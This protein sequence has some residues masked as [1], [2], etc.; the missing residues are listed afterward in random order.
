MKKIQSALYLAMTSVLFLM[1][2]GISLKAAE[3]ISHQPEIEGPAHSDISPPM[4]EVH[5]P[6]SQAG[7]VQRPR[8]RI[9]QS[10]NPTSGPDGALQQAPGTEV[11]SVPA[12]SFG[13]V[14]A[15]GYAPPDTNMAVGPNYIVQWVNLS[16]SVYDK[17]GNKLLGPIG[18]NTIWTGFGAPCDSTNSSDP[19]A[20]YDAIA[21][22]WVMSELAYDNSGHYF[23][24]FAVSKGPDPTGEYFRYSYSFSTD[25]ND[26]PKVAIWPSGY[27][28][29]YNMFHPILGG[30]LGYSFKGA[31][32]CAYD[33]AGMLAGNPTAASVCFQLGSGYGGLLPSDLDGGA[34]FQPP[35]GSPGFFVNFGINSLNLWKLMPNFATPSSSTFTGPTNIPVAA[36]S[37]ACSGGGTCIPQLDTTQQ[38][39]SLADRLMYRLAYRNFG[40]HESIV[41]NHSVTAGS[42]VGVRW[43]EIRSPNGTPTVYQQGTYAPDANYRWM[44]SVAMDKAGNIGL[45]YSVSST[46]MHPSIRYTGRQVSDP[47]GTMT[48]AE[49]SIVEGTGSQQATLSRWGDY[50]A[51]RI[52]PRDDCTFWYTNEYLDADGTFNWRTQIASFSF[53]SCGG[54]PSPDFTIAVQ[55]PNS[56]TVTQGASG[57]FTVNIAPLNGFTGTVALSATVSPLNST[58]TPAFNPPSVTGAGSSTLTVSTTASTTPGPYT[59]TITGTSGSL[60]HS[61][62]VTLVVNPVNPPDFS[63]SASPASRNVT[64][65]NSTT[66]TVTV[67]RLYGFSGS[68][69]LNVSGL[70]SRSSGSSSPNPV[71]GSGNSSTLTIKTNRN[72]PTGTSPLTITGTSGSLNHSTGVSLVVQ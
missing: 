17:T 37:A 42:S 72:T 45:G 32:A 12:T 28:A 27:F 1:L 19:I 24:C 70:P 3:P 66:Y 8:P 9:P 55:P 36:F 64:R 22:R 65:G 13:G 30:L 20:Q 61:T 58:I 63:I 51:M 33:R 18:G 2:S 38:L 54:P 67:T 50:S 44:G 43:Y 57:Q 39:D 31:K 47:L 34:A 40:D 53:A 21:D 71:S 25:L 4:R 49:Q 35:S 7:N 15:T 6:P 48:L 56:A 26:Y 29:T 46:S 5:A 10:P 16:Y 41:V 69:S 62:T 11:G 23:Q 68:V 60:N 52:D 59:V 14:G